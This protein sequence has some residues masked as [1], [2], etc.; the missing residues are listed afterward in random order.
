LEMRVGRAQLRHRDLGRVGA[1]DQVA[2]HVI[3]FDRQPGLDVAE[4]RGG[5]RRAFGGQE[6]A[7]TLEERAAR[8]VPGIGGDRAAFVEDAEQEIPAAGRGQDVAD[9]GPHQAGG[10]GER[11]Q[12]YPL[13]PHVLHHV[14]AGGRAVDRGEGLGDRAHPVRQPAGAFTESQGLHRL[15]LHHLALFIQRRR[16][17]TET[18]KHVLGAER[19]VERIEMQHAV[20]QRDDRGLVADR[21]RERLDRVLEVER[22]AAQQ[23]DVEFVGE[24]VG[25]HRR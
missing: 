6:P 23:H 8:H 3:G 21:W 19:L 7:G 13:L 12:E 25:L 20:E 15:Q 17:R 11:G 22:L 14:L 18:A 9:R 4:H 10:R 16:D 1:H 24:L 2:D 5:H